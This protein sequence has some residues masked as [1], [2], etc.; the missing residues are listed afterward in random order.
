MREEND[1][2]RLSHSHLTAYVSVLKDEHVSYVT[3]D[4]GATVLLRC[5]IHNNL[6]TYVLQLLLS[7]CYVYNMGHKYNSVSYVTQWRREWLEKTVSLTLDG[8]CVC[9]ERWACFICNNT[10][11]MIVH[12]KEHTL[13]PHRIWIAS[14][15]LHTSV[16]KNDI[17][18]T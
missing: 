12:K 1:W 8:L 7:H 13:S 15:F 4:R 17:F 11:S 9:A 14:S 3:M 2:K 18:H 10:C 6:W 5:Y 16:T